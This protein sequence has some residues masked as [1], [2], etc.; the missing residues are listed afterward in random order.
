MLDAPIRIDRRIVLDPSEIEEEFLRASGPGGQNVNKVSSA[1][2]LRFDVARS[3]LP[4]DVRAR[5]ARLAGRKLT[6]GGVLVILAQRH[7]TQDANRRDAYERL[8][9]L[10][11]EAAIAP[12]PRRPTRPSRSAKRKRRESKLHRGSLKDL[13]RKPAED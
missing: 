11:R 3:T 12:A 2:R 7:R 13:R 4:A 1:V 8:I 10:L 9:A 5:L 6:A